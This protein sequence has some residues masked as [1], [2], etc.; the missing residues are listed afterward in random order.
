MKPVDFTRLPSA[1]CQGIGQI[2][3]GIRTSISILE[4]G[5]W[6]TYRLFNRTITKK[7]LLT[8][9]Q[10]LEK[11]LNGGME[12][13][14]ALRGLFDPYEVVKGDIEG[15]PL[16]TGYY[17]PVLTG[18]LTRSS[19]FSVP[20]LARPDDLIQIR[21]SD[22][23]RRLPASSLWG[24]I[25]GKR[26]VPY[27]S[28][29]EID[30]RLENHLGSLPV[31]CWLKNPADLLE[32]QIQ[33][34]G[35]IETNKGK[36]FIHYAAS[37]GRPYTSLG[38]LLLKK[39]ILPLERLD[40]SSIR[41]WAEKNPFLFNKLLARNERYVFFKWETVGPV[42]CYGQVIVPMVSAAFDKSVYPPGLPFLIQLSLP[43]TSR[44]VPWLAGK[45][46]GQQALLLMNHDTGGAIR[47]PLRID[48][49]AGTGRFAGELAGRL[50]NRA[51]M[52]VLVPR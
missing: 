47:G 51:R 28:R 12:V 1:D 32:L 36:R 2:E 24:R 15:R 48:L 10:A 13:K 3:K 37:N 43:P 16:V 20:V 7:R 46:G 25:S 22:F 17:Q 14:E 11:R 49:Y 50:K 41:A 9:L 23:N 39:K 52:F 45:Q 4:A 21:L 26:L 33:G 8:A 19:G 44:T 6:D 29:K 18:A 5:R 31:L 34:S 40:W 35:I 42:G 27:Y 30:E 38:R